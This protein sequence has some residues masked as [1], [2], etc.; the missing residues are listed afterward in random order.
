MYLGREFHEPSQWRDDIL[1]GQILISR[2]RD[3]MSI[4]ISINACSERGMTYGGCTAL[5]RTVVTWAHMPAPRPRRARP[6]D[7]EHPASVF[8]VTQHNAPASRPGHARPAPGHGEQPRPHAHAEAGAPA[9]PRSRR[10]PTLGSCCEGM[11]PLAE[12][13]AESIAKGGPV[14]SSMTRL[15][16]AGGPSW[17]SMTRLE[18][19]RGPIWLSRTSLEGQGRAACDPRMS[20]R[21]VG[22]HAA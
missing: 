1:L 10:I 2:F 14:W 15:E 20:C 3:V 19:D 9:T 18:G 12:E 6:A 7:G 22:G 11:Q 4:A 17:S 5:T 8:A 13:C 21:G 16:G